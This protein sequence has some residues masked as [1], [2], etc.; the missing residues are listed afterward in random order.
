MYLYMYVYY[1]LLP[2]HI[3]AQN[4]TNICVYMQ[5]S[6]QAVLLK[7]RVSCAEDLWSFAVYL[8]IEKT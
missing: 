1:I 6:L 7:L 2:L 3:P 5:V 8:D 4:N